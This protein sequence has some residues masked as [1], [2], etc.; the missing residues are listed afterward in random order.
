VIAREYGLPAV[1]GVEHATRL[2]RDGQWIRVHGT[3]GYVEILSESG[4]TFHAAASN[5]H[6]GH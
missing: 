3:D 1:V 6:K 4:F 5:Q 2:I